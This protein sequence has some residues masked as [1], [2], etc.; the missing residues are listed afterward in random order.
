MISGVTFFNF[1]G[2]NPNKQTR[3]VLIEKQAYATNRTQ[4]SEVK[5]GYSSSS[6]TTLVFSGTTNFYDLFGNGR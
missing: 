6:T 3:V 2:Q 5:G 4:Y 1:R